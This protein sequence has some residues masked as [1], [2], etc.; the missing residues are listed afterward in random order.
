MAARE[1]ME[2]YIAQ[3]DFPILLTNV[4]K[5]HKA[6]QPPTLMELWMVATHWTSNCSDLKDT[7]NL[8]H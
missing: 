3:L 1:N 7:F 6:H 8:K 4:L 5:Y 2:G